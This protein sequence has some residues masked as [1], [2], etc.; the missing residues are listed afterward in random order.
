MFFQICL[1]IPAF[2]P[3]RNNVQF[4]ENLELNKAFFKFHKKQKRTTGLTTKTDKKY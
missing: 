3:E 1:Q 2:S 4:R